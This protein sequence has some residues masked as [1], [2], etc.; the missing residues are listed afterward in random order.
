MI[1]VFWL[2]SNNVIDHRCKI[3][4][5]MIRETHKVTVK[6]FTYWVYITKH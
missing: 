5:V 1:N 3:G 4:T 2:F 6:L